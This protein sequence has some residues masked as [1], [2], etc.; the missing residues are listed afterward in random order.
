MKKAL[1]LIASSLVIT[2]SLQAQFCIGLKTGINSSSLIT[3]KNAYKTEDPRYGWVAGVFIRAKIHNISF[4]PEI[5]YSQKGGD[6]SASELTP[7][8][9]SNIFK[10]KIDAFDVPLIFGMHFSN[11]FHLNTG[12]VMSFIVKEKGHSDI[13]GHSSIKKILSD[14]FYL[15]W[16]I[17]AGIEFLEFIFDVRYELG[18][19]EIVKDFSLGPLDVN[20]NARINLWQITIAYKL[21]GE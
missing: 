17:G 13:S 16:Q 2:F 9:Y 14:E 5:L 10:N 8:N 19:S 7:L 4:Q 1:V 6:Y 12:P 21:L 15:S 18:L 11:F 3:G 20:P